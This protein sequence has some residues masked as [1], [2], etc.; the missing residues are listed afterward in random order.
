MGDQPEAADHAEEGARVVALVGDLY[1][2][3]SPEGWMWAL[4]LL[5]ARAL[6]NARKRAQGAVNDR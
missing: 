6:D 4:K 5:A 3:I 1:D 2:T